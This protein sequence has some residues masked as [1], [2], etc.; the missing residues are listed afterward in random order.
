MV[1]TPGFVVGGTSTVQLQMPPAAVI[2][3]SSIVGSMV[4]G[5]RNVTLPAQV[6]PG[7]VETPIVNVWP[8]WTEIG[9]SENDGDTMPMSIG[10]CACAISLPVGQMNSDSA[11]IRSTAGIVSLRRGLSARRCVVLSMALRPFVP[12]C[13]EKDATR[14]VSAVQ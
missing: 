14:T 13:S 1:P 5:V 3:G 4:G 11:P 8:G 12:A 10:P 9:S 6:A 7:A 2:A